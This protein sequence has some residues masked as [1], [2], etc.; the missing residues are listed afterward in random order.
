MVSDF[1]GVVVE[2]STIVVVF[3]GIL[4]SASAI[5]ELKKHFSINGQSGGD[6]CHRIYNV[7]VTVSQLE[8]ELLQGHRREIEVDA[9]G[10]RIMLHRAVADSDGDGAEDIAAVLRSHVIG[11]TE[12]C[13]AE[14]AHINAL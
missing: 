6:I 1:P 7:V 9:V 11:V 2:F 12:I 14:V 3:S 13:G 8:G 4:A 5:F 10:H